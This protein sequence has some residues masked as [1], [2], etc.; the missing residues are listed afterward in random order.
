MSS[1][2]TTCPNPL[3]CVAVSTH[4]QPGDADGGGRGE[5]RVEEVRH[6]S[7]E[8]A[9]I[10]SMSTPVPSSDR[11]REGRDDASCRPRRGARA[12]AGAPTVGLRAS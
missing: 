5:Q 10:G 6:G 8:R 2:M 1:M 9:E 12:R 7:P 3:Q 11:C 4:R